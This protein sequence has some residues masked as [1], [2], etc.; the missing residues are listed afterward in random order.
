MSS[1]GKH[2]VYRNIG[3]VGFSD[4]SVKEAKRKS[5]FSTTDSIEHS[6][7]VTKI[8]ATQRTSIFSGGKRSAPRIDIYGNII[9]KG[10]KSHKVSFIDNVSNQKIAEVIMVD[11]PVD[12]MKER[13]SLNCASSCLII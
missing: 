3:R 11:Q 2:I 6:T 1:A 10:S 12:K 13:V 7:K 4:S 8:N 9:M 5:I